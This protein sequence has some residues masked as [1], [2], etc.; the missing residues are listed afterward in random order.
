MRVLKLAPGGR[1]QPHRGPGGRL[2]AHLGIKVPPEAFLTVAGQT[3]RWREGGLTVFD[4]AALHSAANPSPRPRYILHVAFPKPPASQAGGFGLGDVSSATAAADAPQQIPGSSG[5]A[6]AGVVARIATVGVELTVFGN[7][8][9]VATNKHNGQSSVPEPLLLLYNRV[10]DNRPQDWEACIRASAFDNQTV[11]VFANHGYG[12]VDIGIIAYARWLRFEVLSL[13]QWNADP[14]QKHLQFANLC[15]A[16]LCGSKPGA[17]PQNPW[18]GGDPGGS[19]PYALP[20]DE[21]SSSPASGAPAG[22]RHV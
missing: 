6:A 18:P 22:V 21:R 1:L 4:D 19:F 10:A 15:P 16:D 14:V 11:R 5:G 3:L 20:P 17:D 2:V 12:S 9:A 7:C 8:S 13:T